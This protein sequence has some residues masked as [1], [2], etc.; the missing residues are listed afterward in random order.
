MLCR[1][2]V[3]D[4]QHFK[5]DDYLYQFKINFDRDLCLLDLVIP[6]EPE[7]DED[8]DSS[9][10]DESSQVELLVCISKLLIVSSFDDL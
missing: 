1:V 2:A 3:T 8:V 10:P 4:S 7:S 6:P 9:Q 5:D